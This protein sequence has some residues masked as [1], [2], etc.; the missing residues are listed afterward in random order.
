MQG[1]AE[2]V[3]ACGL[4]DADGSRRNIGLGSAAP[5]AWD[6]QRIRPRGSGR[7]VPAEGPRSAEARFATYLDEIAAVLGRASRAASARAYC[8]GLLLPGERKSLEPMAAR[9]APDRVQ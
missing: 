5:R 8:T 4:I 7:E 1:G 6:G 2:A 9:T 3:R